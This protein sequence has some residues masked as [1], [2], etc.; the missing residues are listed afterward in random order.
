VNKNYLF[1]PHSSAVSFPELDIYPANVKAAHGST[2][3][4]F[5]ENNQLIFY[6]KSRAIDPYLSFHLVLLSLL[7]ETFS[8]CP[9]KL[10]NLI[11]QWVEKKL[12][13]LEKSLQ[14]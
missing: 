9:L 3:S 6:L 14:L 7:K 4:P 12:I 5:F 11:R 8:D 10:Q 2:I 1:S 13:S